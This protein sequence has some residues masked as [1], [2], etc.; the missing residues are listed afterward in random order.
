MAAAAAAGV[1]GLGR[2]AGRAAPSAGRKWPVSQRGSRVG[3][4]EPGRPRGGTVAGRGAAVA[5]GLQTPGP[6]S[7]AHEARRRRAWQ[8]R[9]QPEPPFVWVGG[10]CRGGLGI[11]RE[12]RGTEGPGA[13]TAVA[14]PMWERGECVLREGANLRSFS[15]GWGLSRAVG[16]EAGVRKDLGGKVG[17]GDG[18]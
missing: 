7:V 11:R 15:M 2:W 13:A 16:R 6:A 18:G 12:G 8:S 14:E 5:G 9:T 17:S 1:G 4:A 10:P 3:S